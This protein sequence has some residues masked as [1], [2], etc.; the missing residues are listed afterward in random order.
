MPPFAAREDLFRD[1]LNG[2]VG[3][4]ACRGGALG[5]RR[6]RSALGTAESGA[7]HE[8]GPIR[9]HLITQLCKLVRGKVL[10]R[11]I[12]KIPLRGMAMLPIDRITG[13]IGEPLQL[14]SRLRQHGGIEFLTDDPLPHQI[15][16]SA[17]NFLIV[18]MEYAH[19]RPLGG[20]ISSPCGLI[21]GK[22]PDDFPVAA[23][24]FPR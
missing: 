7:E 13:R 18:S 8:E 3:V 17:S 12:D 21:I 10:R 1:L 4:E 6:V 9:P 2:E 23:Y 11:D 22:R 15:N 20:S 16:L 19:A 5:R 24:C 14:T